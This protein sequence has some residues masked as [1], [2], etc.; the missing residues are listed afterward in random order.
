ML[1]FWRDVKGLKP[2]YYVARHE[3]IFFWQKLG[4][5]D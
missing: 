5:T 1:I 4:R 2:N 3:N